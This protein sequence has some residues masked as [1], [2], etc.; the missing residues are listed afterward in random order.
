MNATPSRNRNRSPYVHRRIRILHNVLAVL[1]LKS[2]CKRDEVLA[3]VEAV[4]PAPIAHRGRKAMH[5]ADRGIIEI[6]SRSKPVTAAIAVILPS[7]VAKPF[8]AARGCQ[9]TVRHGKQ[10]RHSVSAAWASN[11]DL[12]SPSVSNVSAA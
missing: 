5:K 8:P 9:T 4:V 2:H 6:G 3:V 10:E 11:Q 7:E 1:P 12:V